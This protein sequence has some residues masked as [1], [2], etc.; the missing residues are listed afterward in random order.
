MVP[1]AKQL[2]PGAE[3]QW[4]LGCRGRLNY[5]QGTYQSLKFTLLSV[6]KAVVNA[7]QYSMSKMRV[8]DSQVD[9]KGL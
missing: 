3:E 6:T 4:Q 8:A 9:G 7:L 2:T 5:I 1:K